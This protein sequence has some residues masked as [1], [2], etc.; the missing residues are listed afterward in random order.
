VCPAC[1]NGR[2]A[3]LRNRAHTYEY[4]ACGRQTSV[5]AGTAMHRSKLLL[6]VWFWTANLMTIRSNGMSA[7]QFEAQL[8]LT[9]KTAWLLAHK[10][11]SRADP[12]REPLEG[13]V[14]VDQ[15]EIPFR[16]DDSLF[17][18]VESG[19]ILVAGAIE[20]IDRGID[21]ARP[22]PKGAKYLDTRCGRIRLAAIADNSAVSLEVFV[23]A[24]VK[25]G[26]TL[27]TMCSTDDLCYPHPDHYCK[28][29]QSE[30]CC[31]MPG[32]SARADSRSSVR[33]LYL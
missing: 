2:A 18:P 16:A 30:R 23:R 3:L 19:K 21:Q 10:L 8:G 32:G 17:G 33:R 20:A 5:T 22:R 11:Q 4:R 25:L 9:D 12:E 7:L 6:T 29:P 28:L 26:T 14:E 24:N 31:R 27:L 15:A 1:G 13:V